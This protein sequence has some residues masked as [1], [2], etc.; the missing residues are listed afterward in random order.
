MLRRIA[1]RLGVPP[2]RCVLVEDT[3]VHQQSA[4]RVGMGTVWMQRFAR[5]AALPDVAPPRWAMQPAYVDRRVRALG[6]LLG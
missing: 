2:G 3:L 4:R 6:Q 5:R 1:V